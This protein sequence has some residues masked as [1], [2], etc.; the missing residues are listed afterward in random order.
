MSGTLE[1][2]Q[3]SGIAISGIAKGQVA[4]DMSVSSEVVATREERR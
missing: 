4:L 3:S 2:D 1:K